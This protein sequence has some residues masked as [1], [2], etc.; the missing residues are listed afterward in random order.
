VSASRLRVCYF[1][2]AA[3]VIAL[4][5]AS[6]AWAA[7]RLRPDPAGIDVVPGLV[8]FVYAENPGIAFSLFDSGASAT[9]WLLSAF[10]TVAAVAVVAYALRTDA[11]LFRLQVTFALLLGGIVGNLVDRVRTGRVVDFIDVYVSVYHWPTF[12]VADSA[13]SVGAALLAL[14]MLR[15]SGHE[16]EPRPAEGGA[17]DGAG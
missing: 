7:G 12:N 9:R 4:D 11:R 1:G 2:L 6:K 8:R 14:E 13:I 16:S 15:G 3:A 5:Q 10:S 17:A